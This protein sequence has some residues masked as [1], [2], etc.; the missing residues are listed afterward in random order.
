MKN[1]VTRAL[2]CFAVVLVWND[3]S[4]LGQDMVDP[5]AE[6]VETSANEDVS[7]DVS[8]GTA[9]TAPSQTTPA[10]DT[11]RAAGRQE[12]DTFLL[13]DKDGK[14]Q[15]VLGFQFEDFFQAYQSQFGVGQ[16]QGK[17]RFTLQRLDASGRAYPDRAEL[18]IELAVLL[19][20]DQW[21]GVPLG[22][23]QSI[24]SKS[25]TTLDPERE[26]LHYDEAGESYVLWLRGKPAEQRRVTFDISVPVAR[27][28]DESIL[29]LSTPRAVGS[30]LK[31][32]V[33]MESVARAS[34][35][36][37]LVSR[38]A[39]D[40]ESTEFVAEGLGGSF[41]LAWREPG[42]LLSRSTSAL[43]VTGAI[44][45]RVDSPTASPTALL[46]VE[47]LG[48][49]LH[50]FRVRLPAGTKL[51]STVASPY[52]ITQ[53]E[54]D[55]P[56]APAAMTRPIVV[57]QLG[58]K[59]RGPVNIR[60]K[61]E[62]TP[63]A[64]EAET[65]LDLAGF[66]VLGAVRQTG[67][68]AIQV[69]G[70]WNVLWEETDPSFEG[71]H[72]V[73]V[74]DLP[75][76][77]RNGQVQYAF[78]YFR[79]PSRLLTQV[80]SRQPH[81]RVDPE[82]V[83]FVSARRVDL[84]ARLNYFV[85]D[86]KTFSFEVDM[87]D[88]EIDAVGPPNI[89]DQW[90][91][92]DDKGVVLAR[93]REPSQGS[94]RLEIRAHRKFDDGPFANRLGDQST[95]RIQFALPVPDV[96][97]HTPATVV[98]VPDDNIVIEPVTGEMPGLSPQPAMSTFIELP[99]RQQEP[100]YFRSDAA[101]AT[102]LADV[103]VQPQ[104]VRSEISAQIVLH[105]QQSTVKQILK[106][107][108]AYEPVEHVLLHLP[109]ELKSLDQ[110]EV[111]LDGEKL[112]V[113]EKVP[114]PGGPDL[115]GD[116]NLPDNAAQL[117]SVR[118]A[119]GHARIG[120]FALQIQ[121]PFALGPLQ[122]QQSVALTVPIVKPADGE[123]SE[124]E[125]FVTSPNSIHVSPKVSVGK[126]VNSWES[127]ELVGDRQSLR[128]TLRMRWRGKVEAVPLSVQLA[129]S[130]AARATILERVWVQSWFTP[131]AR[132]DRVAMVIRSSSGLLRVQ[133]PAGVSPDQLEVKV[134]GQIKSF[135]I[136]TAGG[137]EVSLSPEMNPSQRI[138]LR[139]ELPHTGLGRKYQ[140]DFARLLGTVSERNVYWQLVLPQNE[141]LLSAPRELT[142]EFDWQW[143]GY[144]WT[145]RSQLDQRQLEQWV[146]AEMGTPLP[147]RT[148]RYV[149][150]KLGSL[151]S[152]K[153]VSASRSYIVLVVSGSALLA[154]LLLMTMPFP[155]KAGLLLALA[156]VLLILA[157]AFPDPAIMAIQAAALG[158]GLALVA[159]VLQRL[160]SRSTAAKVVVRSG[161]STVLRHLTATESLA[162]SQAADSASSGTTTMAMVS[163]AP[164][165]SESSD[166]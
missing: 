122:P 70:N 96:R 102:F 121:F 28:D 166:R 90:L 73:E 43:S 71:V 74:V 32:T 113:L 147:R 109:P 36:V 134:N 31:L 81:L 38:R 115:S 151:D 154:G 92:S 157:V 135:R 91:L 51:A 50:Q 6:V 155:K 66:D 59:Q 140:A 126:Q 34:E 11:R 83:V 123:I 79:Q 129:E 15:Q 143:Q 55:D 137:I 94:E 9:Q 141:H 10:E 162:A 72:Q 161:G 41:E 84:H 145:R 48:A 5:P 117:S 61:T 53:L 125:V 153:F 21:V 133:L 87:L 158:V 27:R 57:V 2:V 65:P 98:I 67:D 58:S 39:Q 138:E 44:S 78:K 152:V 47:S 112:K 26:F 106:Y 130:Q 95:R 37:T 165:V 29:R 20:T 42:P 23:G 159:A 99:Q 63:E 104:T 13:P 68:I 114:L 3:R 22:L 62:R 163:P 52:T 146:G 108:V 139:Y 12:P 30:R 77:L 60:L 136:G 110:F 119:L 4:G 75:E 18:K 103:T 100:L 118:V 142:A 7:S 97:S 85:G 150:S 69:D 88:W 54:T 164:S 19:H 35:G 131:S 14:L 156:T 1:F 105:E 25:P 160:L 45:L 148:N 111:Q 64:I 80:I 149:F 40:G 76:E 128:H 89:V 46:N 132:Q 93:L 86:A 16:P 107:H 82:Y 127:V 8:S 33:N 101:H 24:L 17:P 56:E 49:P 124:C 120:S 116:P 144:Y